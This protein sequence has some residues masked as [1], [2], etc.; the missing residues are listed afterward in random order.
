[1]SWHYNNNDLDNFGENLIHRNK[2]FSKFKSKDE[3]VSVTGKMLLITKYR[4]L[5]SE[6]KKN[7]LAVWTDGSSRL[8][9][10][11]PKPPE[12]SITIVPL[13]QCLATTSSTETLLVGR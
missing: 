4:S 5:I 7:E 3:E 11:E 10:I 8:R 2:N 13:Q 6:R 1:M 9:V 12:S